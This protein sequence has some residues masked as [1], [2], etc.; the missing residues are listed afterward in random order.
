VIRTKFQGIRQIWGEKK[1]SYGF[2]GGK[3]EGKR[4]LGRTKHRL[5]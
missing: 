4:S 1:I 2:G 3:S 5:G